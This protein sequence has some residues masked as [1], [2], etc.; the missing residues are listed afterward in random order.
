[1]FTVDEFDAIPNKRHFEYLD[2]FRNAATS[3][4][5]AGYLTRNYI[6]LDAL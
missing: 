4:A 5:R 2:C 3:L 6:I 1:M